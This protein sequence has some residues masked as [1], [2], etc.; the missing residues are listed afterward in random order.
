MQG[1]LCSQ[2][3]I[4][5]RSACHLSCR[6]VR[7]NSAVSSDMV[8]SK[9]LPSSRATEGCV[10]RL[11]AGR[12]LPGRFWHGCCPV[13]TSCACAQAR[14]ARVRG[15]GALLALRPPTA[16]ASW[17]RSAADSPTALIPCPRPRRVPFIDHTL[18]DDPVARWQCSLGHQ[19]WSNSTS[20]AITTEG[21][22]GLIRGPCAGRRPAP[23]TAVPRILGGRGRALPGWS[24]AASVLCLPW[25]QV[26]LR[27]PGRG[28]A[29]HPNVLRLTLSTRNLAT[30]CNVDN[31]LCLVRP[32]PAIT[33]MAQ[34][35]AVDGQRFDWC[36]LSC[37]RDQSP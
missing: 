24:A 2:S 6:N 10:C 1:T 37:R 25:R 8:A 36:N 33:R 22:T 32:L 31:F 29:L 26:G 23:A 19:N 13:S 20:A 14:G 15:G 3:V 12:M 30:S 35:C 16:G 17:C 27:R 7:R 11:E 9:N 18:P 34:S 5:S 28:E 4:S 21:E